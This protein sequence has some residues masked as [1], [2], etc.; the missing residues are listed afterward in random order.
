MRDKPLI[1]M[2]E[3]TLS[4][5]AIYREYLK[6]EPYEVRAVATG[7]DAMVSIGNEPPDLVLLDLKLP[8]MDGTDI[9]DVRGLGVTFTDVIANQIG[10]NTVVSFVGVSGQITMTNFNATDIDTTDFFF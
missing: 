9:L 8:D 7:K 2:V 5:A 1:L 10:A 4:L 6:D 3:D